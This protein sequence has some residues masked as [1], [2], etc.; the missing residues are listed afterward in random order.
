M[1]KAKHKLSLMDAK[2]VNAIRA[3][4]AARVVLAKEAGNNYQYLYH[5]FQWL[6]V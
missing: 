6:I 5:R 3:K 1:E 2:A 4:Q